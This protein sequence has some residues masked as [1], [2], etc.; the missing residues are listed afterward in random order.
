VAV[1]TAGCVSHHGLYHALIEQ[2]GL[3]YLP[4]QREI[5]HLPDKPTD[6]VDADDSNADGVRDSAMRGPAGGVGE[7]LATGGPDA[8]TATGCSRSRAC[9][10]GVVLVSDVMARPLVTV[11]VDQIKA[12]VM[13]QLASELHHGFP[14]TAADG[15]LA[16]LLTADEMAHFPSETPVRTMMDRA[17][18]C[19]SPEWPLDRA[20]R[21]FIALGL[22]HLLVVSSHSRPVGMITRHDLRQHGT[23]PWHARLRSRHM[24]DG[25]TADDPAA[26]SLTLVGSEAPTLAPLPPLAALGHGER[27]FGDAAAE[28]RGDA[29]QSSEEAISS[30]S[31]PAAEP[32]TPAST[33]GAGAALPAAS[34]GDEMEDGS[35]AEVD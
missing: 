20:H 7:P 35:F 3:P 9:E 24:E 19:I 10:G 29:V 18:A 25:G 2:A 14:V 26:P 32:A 31:L 5:D 33:A 27:P 16:G 4:P 13:L 22:R 1:F 34:S 15:T 8:S 21:V 28:G 17:P 6:A 11:G 23:A 12:A 30:T